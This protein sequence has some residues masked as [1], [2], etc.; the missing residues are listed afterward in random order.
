MF[1]SGLPFDVKSIHVEELFSTCGKVANCKLI[2]FEDT[3]RCKGQAYIAF[4]TEE[5]AQMALK[6]SGTTVNA[7]KLVGKKDGKK[8]KQPSTSLPKK[9]LKLSVSKMLN[10]RVTK[11]I[12]TK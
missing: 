8:K 3:G 6:L 1:V 10:R 5:A 11:R 2:K 4:E 7:E 12:K 9:D